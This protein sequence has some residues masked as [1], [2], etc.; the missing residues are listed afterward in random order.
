MMSDAP[1]QHRL[2]QNLSTSYAVIGDG[3]DVLALHG[4]GGS[5]ASFWPV[6]EGLSARGLRV[7][8]LDLP[9]FGETALPP[10]VWGV[11][12]YARFV[13]DFLDAL[14]L[15]RV[16]LLGHSFGGRIGLILGADHPD[17]IDKMVLADSAGVK[18][19]DTAARD[20]IVKAGKAILKLPGL[21]RL[22][23][24][25][26]RKTYEALGSTD[27]LD[28]GPLQE[29]FVRV[30]EQDL[31]PYAAR[32][33]RPTLLIWGDQDQDTP[34]EQ[35]RLLEKTIPDA[36]LVVYAGAGHFSYLDRLADYLRVVTHFLTHE[37]A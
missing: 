18:P 30:I 9:G 26:R 7:Y 34:L 2:V 5:I 16:H 33:S 20:A 35:G 14:G 4:W 17:R 27:Y 25:L 31:L 13:L 24:P 19:P 29:T 15:Q 21:N 22:Y 10:A 3:P 12:E 28:A 1:R 11:P 23:E 32:V 37:G 6:A 8:V 36:G